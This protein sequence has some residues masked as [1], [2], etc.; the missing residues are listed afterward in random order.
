MQT[1]ERYEAIDLALRAYRRLKD[2]GVLRRGVILLGGNL[3][4][5]AIAAALFWVLREAIVGAWSRA[6]VFAE[7]LDFASFFAI[8]VQGALAMLLLSIPGWILL[9]SIEAANLRWYLRGEETGGPLAIRLDADTWRVMLSQVLVYLIVFGM[10]MGLPGLF[11]GLVFASQANQ[12]LAIIATLLTVL[13]M[14]FNLVAVPYVAMRIAP[15]AAKAVADANLSVGRTWAGMRGRMLQ[16]FLAIVLL[17]IVSFVISQVVG[18]ALQLTMM[19]PLMSLMASIQTD[20]TFD[21]ASLL[22]MIWSPGA[23]IVFILFSLLGSVLNYAM[24]IGLQAICA[25]AVRDM[26]RIPTDA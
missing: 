19:A 23:V 22:D 10:W 15:T 2:G 5:A 3:V 18:I 20:P 21:P 9:A 8:W 25:G 6:L 24:A 13:A 14:L 1:T 4:L 26:Q 17:F 7:A 11:A 12:V 16:P